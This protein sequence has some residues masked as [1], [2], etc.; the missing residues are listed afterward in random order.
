MDRQKPHG[1]GGNDPPSAR[2]RWAGAELSNIRVVIG[3][4]PLTDRAAVLADEIKA[5]CYARCEGMSLAAVVGV[6]EIVKMEIVRDNP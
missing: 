2:H 5:L 4:T 1:R 3:G 6:L